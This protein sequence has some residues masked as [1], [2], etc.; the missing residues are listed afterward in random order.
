MSSEIEA[1]VLS[2]KAMY[3]ASS[4]TTKTP[5]TP[6]SST[7]LDLDHSPISPGVRLALFYATTFFVIGV[8]MPFWPAWLS[9]KG[10][11]P[12]EIGILLSITTWTRVIAG[13]LVAQATDRLGRRKPFLVG[14]ALMTLCSFWLYTQAGN[15]FTFATVAFL[16]GCS[17]SPM[18]PLAETTTLMIT[19]DR[20]LDYGRIRLWGSITF[21]AASWGGGLWLAG[22]SED[23]VI[24]LI[25][26]GC[27]S[28]VCSCFLLP[29]V[30]ISKPTNTKAPIRRLLT[31]PIFILFLASAG[32][33]QG[34]H[35]AFYGFSTIHWQAVGLSE[36]KIGLLWAEGVAAEVLL[37]AFSGAVLRR[38]GIVGLLLIGASAATIR[39]TAT[40]F[41]TDFIGLALTQLLH[42]LTFGATHIASLNFIQRAAPAGSTATAQALYSALGL[43]VASAVMLTI[44]GKLYAD[45]QGIVFLMMAIAAITGGLCALALRKYWSGAQL[46]IE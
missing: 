25:L 22:R 32:L 23:A 19:K 8:Y 21:I 20:G 3:A 28:I 10:L 24:P 41:V 43:G 29:D 38:T 37:F 2:V 27:V 35:A 14:L 5:P 4:M 13:P 7:K 44:A 46:G 6:E 39:W 45:Y 30:R 40:C 11:G 9:G 1:I 17:F 16:L 33:I 31:S 18:I 42:A 26:V 15:F 36:G 12:T 34:S